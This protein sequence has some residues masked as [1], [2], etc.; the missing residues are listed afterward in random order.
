MLIQEIIEPYHRYGVVSKTMV[1]A[2]QT[3]DVL[4]KALVRYTKQ[5]PNRT[6][7]LALLNRFIELRR[8]GE[9]PITA[10]DLMLAAYNL[11]LHNQVEDCLKVWEAKTVDYDTHYAVDIQLVPFAG[12]DV[13]INYLKTQQTAEAREALDYVTRCLTAGDFESMDYYFGSDQLPWFI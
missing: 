2:L 5:Y 12:V 8:T 7:A 13:T 10:D 3:D 4:R 11:A 9:L 1:T 6:F